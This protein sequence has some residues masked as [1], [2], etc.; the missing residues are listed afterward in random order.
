MGKKL[1]IITR[2][3][4]SYEAVVAAYIREHRP[5]ALAERESFA[6][7]PTFENAVRRAALGLTITG[8]THSHQ[9]QVWPKARRAWADHLLANIEL[10]RQV[11]TFEQLFNQVESLAIP[12]IAE[13]TVY[14]ST[15]RIE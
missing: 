12:R 5:G 11:G 14:D 8:K 2:I 4:D 1:P 15:Y 6:Q 9:R 7:E 10:L 3:P 13:M